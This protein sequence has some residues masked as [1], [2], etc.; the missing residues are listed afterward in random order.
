MIDR[1]VVVWCVAAVLGA[2]C[3]TGAG[4][5]V[6]G[7]DGATGDHDATPA[8]DGRPAVDAALPPDA[9]V[10]ADAAIADAAS[11]D[12][13]PDAPPPLVNPLSD[14]FDTPVADLLGNNTTSW[15]VL[16][17]ERAAQASIAG[18]RLELVS[19]NP[20]AVGDNNGWY[21][22]D[23]GPLVYTNVTGNFA[24]AVRLRVV[25]SSDANLPPGGSFRA[26]GLLVR[27]PAGTHEQNENWI[28]YNMGSVDGAYRRE[29]KKTTSSLSGLYLNP[30]PFEEQALLLCR[31]EARFYFF[32]WDAAT[33]VW[34]PE[35]FQPGTTVHYAS[36]I[37]EVDTSG[38]LPLYFN[39][40]LPTQVQVGMMS[41]A[42]Q[43]GGATS[44]TR[45]SY[46]WVG[47]AVNPP[48]SV[49]EC[50]QGFESFSLP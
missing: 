30:Q 44:M 28:M 34:R 19:L 36:P 15:T 16:H 17:P 31:V 41:H 42:W 40:S 23:Y 37:A 50:T 26:G 48:A 11:A 43:Y 49:A 24:V 45:S 6:S 3:A 9:L 4:A 27:D 47:L 13:M 38:T 20:E 46:D 7:Y 22:D 35:H 8:P 18:G 32:F 14:Q 33:Q 29:V 5:A 39:D 12:A 2:G 21:Q 25:D 10:T 1:Q